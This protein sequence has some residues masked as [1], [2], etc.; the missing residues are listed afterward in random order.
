MKTNNLIK[1]FRA[2]FLLSILNL[3]DNVSSTMS[4]G[5]YG[6]TMDD[7]MSML[8]RYDYTIGLYGVLDTPLINFESYPYDI[9]G[10]DTVEAHE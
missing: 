3:V 1:I 4:S 6:F 8:R 7:C 10:T 9:K 2:G 5:F